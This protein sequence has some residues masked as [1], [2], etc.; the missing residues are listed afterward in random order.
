MESRTLCR[1]GNS[2]QAS[3]GLGV[4]ETAAGHV[5]DEGSEQ[6]GGWSCSSRRINNRVT[7]VDGFRDLQL[8]FRR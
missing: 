8:R 7:I 2:G 4:D 1:P 5:A 6:N 3:L